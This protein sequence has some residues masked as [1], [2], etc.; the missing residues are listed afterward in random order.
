MDGITELQTGFIAFV[1]AY[2]GQ[3]MPGLV[4][5]RAVPPKE[6]NFPWSIYFLRGRNSIL[7]ALLD[8]CVE[9]EVADGKLS[10]QSIRSINAELD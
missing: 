8:D 4:F 9:K 6:L 10:D 1:N 7:V 3:Q 5:E 2:V